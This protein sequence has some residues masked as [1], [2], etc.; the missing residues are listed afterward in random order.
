MVGHPILFRSPAGS[1][2]PMILQRTDQNFL[3]SLLDELAGP[4]GLRTLG[5]QV[6]RA[7]DANGALTLFQP[8]HRTFHVALLEAVCQTTGTPSVDPARIQ[9][10]GLVVRRCAVLD[11]GARLPNEYEAWMQD[12]RAPRTAAGPSGHPRALRGWVPLGGEL[13]PNGDPDPAR[14][15]P[16]LRSGH[17]EIDRRL[18]AL[19]GALG[20]TLTESVTPLFLAPPE[21]CAAL[22]KTLLYGL[23]PVT[24]SELSEAPAEFRFELADVR[25]H[26]PQLLRSGLALKVPHAGGY[27]SSADVT[28]AE[29]AV[30]T[31]AGDLEAV[32]VR[33]VGQSRSPQMILAFVAQLRQITIE[34]G[35]FGA[36]PAARALVNQMNHIQL[37]FG[38]LHHRG[39]G[40]FLKDAAAALLESTDGT[41]AM[42]IHWPDIGPDLAEKLA[43]AVRGALSERM[44]RVA[45]HEGRFA[46]PSRE[47]VLRAFVRV[48]LHD[49]CPPKTIWSNPSEPFTIRPWY[50]A[51]DAPPVAIALPDP[52]DRRFLA[53]LKP[54][55]AFV[56]PKRLFNLM[57]S[58]PKKLVAGDGSVSDGGPDVSWICGFNIPIITICAFIVLNI[59]LGLL[60]LIFWWL[61]FVKICIPL[62]KRSPL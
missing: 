24:S 26:M 28:N 22:G 45:P 33:E 55:V 57:N 6:A 7:H 48:Q 8:V 13:D 41:V 25:S 21:L 40:E 62:P 11:S 37:S 18:A 16:A 12:T 4:D 2:G 43:E 15:P 59:F 5:G 29:R 38:R 49:G 35:A 46:G 14:R 54:N 61:P 58:D 60:N 51:S 19:P 36:G 53:Q 17:P 56:L 20:A 23:V 31:A 34:F 27:L 50:A 3:P 9:G 30:G 42:P 47:Y 39:A 1:L 10:A 32:A 52:T 44:T